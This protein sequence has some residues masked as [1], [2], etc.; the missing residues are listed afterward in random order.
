MDGQTDQP[1]YRDA[2][3]TDASKK[4]NKAIRSG[5]LSKVSIT[6]G[7]NQIWRW[8]GAPKKKWFIFFLCHSYTF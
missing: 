6:N 5:G 4:A 8:V 7:H 1:T 2:F 3:L